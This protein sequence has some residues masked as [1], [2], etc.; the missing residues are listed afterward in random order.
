[1]RAQEGGLGGRARARPHPHTAA[2]S[3]AT[4][5]LPR[6]RNMSVASIELVHPAVNRRFDLTLPD[7]RVNFFLRTFD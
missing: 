2:A 7:T 1:M 5:R 6:A 4:N 3:A